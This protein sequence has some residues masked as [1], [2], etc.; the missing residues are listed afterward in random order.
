MQLPELLVPAGDT[1]RLAFALAYG[2]DA[3]Y[4]GADKFG[5]RSASKNFTVEQ[6]AEGVALA[7]SMGKRVY[8]TLNTVPTNEEVDALPDFLESIKDIGLDA[9]I[10]SDIGVLALCKKYCPNTEL[11][12][13]TQVGIMNYAAANAAWEMGAKRVVLARELSLPEI[14]KIRQNTPPELELEAFVHGAM[15][16]SMSGRCLLSKYM[17]NRDGNR[18]ECAQPCRWEYELIEKQRPQQRFEIG[19][20]EGGSYILNADDLCTAPFLDLILAAGITS[21]KIEGR[22][23]SFYYVAS[24]TAAYRRAL[25]AA[26]KNPNDYLCPEQVLDELQKTSHRHYSPGFYFGAEHATQNADYSSYIRQWDV[27]AVV[28]SC[29]GNLAQCTQRG[30]LCVGDTVELLVPSGDTIEFEADVLLDETGD[31]ISATPH[32]LMKFS[33]A[34]PENVPPMSI[35][36]RKTADKA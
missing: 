8:L 27:L 29:E 25:D 12:L 19:Q 15:C 20:N 5:M 9:F 2:A 17:A 13:S 11:H 18:G 14:A 35:L 3:V 16:V 22:A 6:L 32:A 4:L 36:R 1:E 34:V 23:K 31:S 26:L 24:T 7:H 21:L 10:V 28:E 30:K 33:L